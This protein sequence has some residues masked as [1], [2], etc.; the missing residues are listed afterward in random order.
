MHIGMLWFDETAGHD[1]ETTIQT[2]LEYYRRKYKRE[3]NLCL[4]NPGM[5]SG[6]PLQIGHLTV[7]AYASVLPQHLWIGVE[8]QA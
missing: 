8:D 4:V 6:P 1:L 5:I 7:R 3:P 2:A